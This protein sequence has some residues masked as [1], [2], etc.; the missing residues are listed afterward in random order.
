M[1]YADKKKAYLHIC[2]LAWD[3][4]GLK[5]G[6]IRNGR[7]TVMVKTYGHVGAIEV[8]WVRQGWDIR[9][10]GTDTKTVRLNAS[11]P[12]E[13]WGEVIAILELLL[14]I[15]REKAANDMAVPVETF[16]P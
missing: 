9:K 8:S 4:N 11:T 3:I 7:P 13:V 2:S 10:G 12:A 5:E 15:V 6:N 1:T 16:N 14:D